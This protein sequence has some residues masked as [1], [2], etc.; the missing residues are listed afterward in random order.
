MT[1]PVNEVRIACITS[2]PFFLVTQLKRQIEFLLGA[3]MQVTLISSSGPELAQI[4]PHPKL[5]HHMVAIA[6]RLEPWRDLIALFQLIRLF[7]HDQ[8]MIVHSTTPKAGLLTAIAAWLVRVPVR[9]HTFTGQPWVGMRGPLRRMARISDRIIGWLATRCYADSPSQRQFLISEGIISE[10]RIAVIGAGSL[11]GVD[12]GRFDRR[13][14]GSDIRVQI[15][16]ELGLSEQTVVLVFVGRIARDKGI[17]EL[18][19]AVQGLRSSGYDLALLVIGPMDDERD[20]IGT[21]VRADLDGKVGVY[22]LGYCAEPEYYLAAADILCLPSY[23][24]GFG[25]VVIEAAALGLPAVGTRIAGLVD[26]VLDGETGIL[27]EPHNAGVLAQGL[28]RL[29]D[30][31]I[32]RTQMGEA[33]YRRTCDLFS[34]NVVNAALVR[35]Y[36]RLLDQNHR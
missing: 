17:Y 24:E 35:E 27:V 7:R 21:V 30:D 19:E 32:L 15:R 18:L 26:A 5:S 4:A 2:V 33:A 20:G 16:R 13:R 6:R 28:R 29:L 8:F 34:A 25:T 22:Y 11:A 1:S 12:I 9:L 10:Q 3:G 23:R 31:P 14:F 36:E